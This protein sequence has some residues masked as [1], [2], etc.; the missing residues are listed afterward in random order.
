MDGAE[1]DEK[2]IKSTIK[3]YSAERSGLIDVHD[4]ANILI[5]LKIPYSENQLER[6]VFIF[7]KDY[8]GK[9]QEKQL[10]KL[11]FEAVLIFSFK[12]DVTSRHFEQVLELI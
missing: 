9:I 12:Y 4:I 6:L 8:T 1:T 11:I 5:E 10:G 2:K 7:D 3:K